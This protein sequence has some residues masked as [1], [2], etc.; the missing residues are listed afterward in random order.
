MKENENVLG[1]NITEAAKNN[2][3][4]EGDKINEQKKVK[5]AGRPRKTA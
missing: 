1:S 3:E 5:R 4:N 2:I